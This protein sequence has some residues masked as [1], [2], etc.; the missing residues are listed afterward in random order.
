MLNTLGKKGS[1]KKGLLWE[2]S[3]KK[4]QQVCVWKRFAPS[5]GFHPPNPPSK[6]KKARI[7]K[8]GFRQSGKAKRKK[9]SAK[10]KKKQKSVF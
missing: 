7:G 2:I 3:K 4:F 10:K 6:D 9:G 5:V 8:E 1:L